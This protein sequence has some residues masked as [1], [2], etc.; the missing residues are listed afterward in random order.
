[1]IVRGSWMVRLAMAAPAADWTLLQTLAQLLEYDHSVEAL[2]FLEDVLTEGTDHAR[3]LGLVRLA[4]ELRALADL[5]GREVAWR[6]PA[7]SLPR[8]T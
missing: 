7:L 8:Q 3:A 6:S 4:G 1:M 5:V 2:L